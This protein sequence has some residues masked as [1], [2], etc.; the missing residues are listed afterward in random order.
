[1]AW[2]ACPYMNKYPSPKV[3]K[4]NVILFIIFLNIKSALYTQPVL[5]ETYLSSASFIFFSISFFLSSSFFFQLLTS[6]SELLKETKVAMGF[7]Y[8]LILWF[9]KSTECS[10]KE[11]FSRT[12]DYFDRVLAC[13]VTYDIIQKLTSTENI[14]FS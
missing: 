3:S 10:L 4:F 1:M 2:H 12:T 9:N 14:F 6:S 11:N 13:H 5:Q 8:H 7:L